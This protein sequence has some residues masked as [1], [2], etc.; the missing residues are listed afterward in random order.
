VLDCVDRAVG[1]HGVDRRV[2][3]TAPQARL[4]FRYR[5]FTS[6]GDTCGSV[7]ACRAGR[8][9]GLQPHRAPPR[10]ASTA[11]TTSTLG[12]YVRVRVS[13]FSSYACYSCEHDVIVHFF[14]LI[15]STPNVCSQVGDYS[16]RSR[17]Q[18]ARVAGSHP[19]PHGLS[20]LA[21]PYRVA[22]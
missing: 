5:N 4:P 15:F 3:A 11:A 13:L 8:P 2:G 1:V 9:H 17:C 19:A 18:R 21:H 6:K 10:H 7:S 20:R 12:S 16:D 14:I 22:L